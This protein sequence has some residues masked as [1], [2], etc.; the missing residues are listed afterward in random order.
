M[1]KESFYERNQSTIWVT[2]TVLAAVGFFFLVM[3]SML[4][5]SKEQANLAC[6]NYYGESYFS[7]IGISNHQTAC[8][9]IEERNGYRSCVEGS[10]VT[11]PVRA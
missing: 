3:G 6:K 4:N 7:N 5:Y 10:E 2:I 9:K 11:L 1:K 8:C